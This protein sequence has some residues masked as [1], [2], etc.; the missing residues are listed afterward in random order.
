MTFKNHISKYKGKKRP[1]LWKYG[2]DKPELHAALVPFLRQKAQAAFRKEP[3]KFKFEEWLA[4]WNGRLSLRG[5]KAN[6]LVMARKDWGK[7]WSTTNVEIISRKEQL[8]KKNNTQHN[9]LVNMS[10]GYV[11]KY[12]NKI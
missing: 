2:A 7:P 6:S 9:K 5:R 10:K 8:T 3:W 11:K 1:D 4:V 12:Y